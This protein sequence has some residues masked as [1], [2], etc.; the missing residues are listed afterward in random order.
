MVLGAVAPDGA[1]VVVAGGAL[2]EKSVPVT[3]VTCEPG[4]TCVGSMAMITAPDKELA[5]ACA[6]ASWAGVLDGVVHDRLGLPAHR[7]AVADRPDVE[8][9]RLQALRRRRRLVVGAGPVQDGHRHRRRATGA[10][11]P[12]TCP[13]CPT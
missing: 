10:C 6:A 11:R 2:T 13:R 5:T 8:T 12:S 4:F 3:T 7:R 1:V 9:E